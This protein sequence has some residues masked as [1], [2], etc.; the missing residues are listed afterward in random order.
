MLG[1][2]GDDATIPALINVLHD[3]S[4]L[5]RGHAA[6]A[7]GRLGGSEARGSLKAVKRTEI[8]LMVLDEINAA[9]DAV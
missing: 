2:L 3:S 9:L 7:L 4:A 8:D 1:N 6:W 5:V